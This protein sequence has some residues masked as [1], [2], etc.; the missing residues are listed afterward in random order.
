MS[1]N[2]KD[3]IY[4]EGEFRHDPKYT[5]AMQKLSLLYCDSAEAILHRKE[6]VYHQASRICRLLATSSGRY[7]G[8]GHF[9]L[10]QEPTYSYNTGWSV[11][12]RFGAMILKVSE[13]V[14]TLGL[15]LGWV[16]LTPDRFRLEVEL[17][18]KAKNE[19]FAICR[20]GL[21]LT[22]QHSNLISDK[23][24][25]SVYGNK[26][27]TDFYQDSKLSYKAGTTDSVISGN[28]DDTYGYKQKFLLASQSLA[29][30]A[31]SLIAGWKEISDYFTSLKKVASKSDPPAEITAEIYGPQFAKTPDPDIWLVIRDAEHFDFI[32]A[33]IALRIERSHASLNIGK[34]TL[35]KTLVCNNIL[36]GDPKALLTAISLLNNC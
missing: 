35:R 14:E 22:E 24:N 18:E 36:Q 28:L 20:I 27:C 19:I 7:Y 32:K 33:H 31:I 11:R 23:T 1:E 12:I 10:Y 15:V 9:S 6:F 17:V 21:K 34:V 29:I 5:G 3:P 25:G 16:T 2:T 4:Y 8:G 13:R 30:S 26:A